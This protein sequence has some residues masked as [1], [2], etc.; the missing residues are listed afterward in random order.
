MPQPLRHTPPD[1]A[2]Y[3]GQRGYRAMPLTRGQPIGYDAERMAYR[4]TM[5]SDGIAVQCDISSSA[6]RELCGSKKFAPESC[7]SVFLQFREHIEHLASEIFD[8][9][10]RASPLRI[11]SKHVR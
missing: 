9:S 10:E 5:I 1:W 4:F 6:L 7:A 2:G 3:C 11:F 8:G